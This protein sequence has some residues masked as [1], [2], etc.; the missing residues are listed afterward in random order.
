VKG[1]WVRGPNA[2]LTPGSLKSGVA[3]E[4]RLMQALATSRVPPTVAMA[5]ATELAAAWR[6]WADGFRVTLPGAYPKLAAVPGPTAPPT[7]AASAFPIAHGNSAGEYRLTAG[8]LGP[9]LLRG[10]HTRG[11]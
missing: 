6:E 1:G 10:R 9:R 7:P 11:H 4:P 5:L 3:I 8:T 2:E